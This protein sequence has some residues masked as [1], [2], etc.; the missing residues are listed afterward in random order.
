MAGNSK[1]PRKA[2][3]KSLSALL[4]KANRQKRQRYQK[5]ND[6]IRLKNNLP[7]AH[8]LNVWKLDKTF[9]P[10]L[11]V[12]DEHDATGTMLADEE[13]KPVMW[14]EDD[15]DY[16]YLIPGVL[17][18]CHVFEL[19]GLALVWGKVPPG[20]NAMALKLARDE[21]LTAGDTDDA[22]TTIAWMREKL[23]KVSAVQWSEKFDW[24]VSLAEQ[25]QAAA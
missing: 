22:R 23:G 21:K 16:M 15:Q 6:R 4:D 2:K 12:L 25:Q 20:L 1:K 14:D 5:L 7:L 18:M 13:G 24:A 17:H 10:L 8:P 11:K 19:V 9:K 3:Q